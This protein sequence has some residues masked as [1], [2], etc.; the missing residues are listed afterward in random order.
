MV[1]V[2]LLSGVWD[3]CLW[4][5]EPQH[6]RLPCPSLFPVCSNSYPS[7]QWCHPT[8][9]PSATLISFCPQSF[10]AL[11][12]PPMLFTSGGQGI[13][14]LASLLALPKNIQGWFPLGWT[15]WISLLFKGLSRVFSNIN[16]MVLSFVYSPTLTFIHDY[17]KNHSFD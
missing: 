13:G 4:P 12:S 15:G 8:I 7:S 16:S 14:A 9:S 17:W 5:H 3:D 6:A 10:P 1:V 2:Q 11:R